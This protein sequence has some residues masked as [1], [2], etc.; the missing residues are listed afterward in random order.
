MIAGNGLKRAYWQELNI[1]VSCSHLHSY[2]LTISTSIN[3]KP[4]PKL[5][6]PFTDSDSKESW[7]KS[8]NLESPFTKCGQEALIQISDS[9]YSPSD[10]WVS[11]N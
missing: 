6:M 10:L 3:R 7:E 9:I 8:D 4:F 5:G 1:Q 2:F 11:T